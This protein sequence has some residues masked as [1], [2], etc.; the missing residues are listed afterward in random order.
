MIMA[1]KYVVV[2]I[3]TTGLDRFKD[4]INYIGFYHPE[5]DYYYIMTEWDEEKVI[6]LTKGRKTILQNGKFDVNFI[7]EKHGYIMHIDIDTLLMAYL[8]VS[9]IRESFSLKKL[10]MKYVGAPDWDVALEEKTGT[11]KAT[12]EYLKGDLKWTWELYKYFRGK[13]SDNHIRLMAK[14]L[15]PALNAYAGIEFRGIYLDKEKLDESFAMLTDEK[16]SALDTLKDYADINWNS[17]KQIREVL[18]EQMGLPVTKRTKTG[19]PSTAKSVLKKLALNHEIAEHLLE[20]K[21]YAKQL[22]FVSKW[23]EIQVNG[24]LYPSFNLTTTA[25][26]RTSSSGPNIQQV[27][28]NK[29][30]RSIFTA[31]TGYTFA[32]IDYSQIELRIG[33]VIANV[34]KF[35]E[36]YKNDGDIHTL[37]AQKLAGTKNITKED[38]TNAKAVNFGF[39]YGMMEE[40]FQEYAYD[41]FGL[42]LTL[43]EAKLFR[44]K[45]FANYPELEHWHKWQVHR[46]K[47]F[48][49]STNLFGRFR[50]LP[51]LVSRDWFKK[52]QDER[53]AINTPVQATASDIVLSGLVDVYN[54]LVMGEY[55]DKLFIVATVHDSL[56]FEIKDEIVDEVLPKIKERMEKPRLLEYFDVDLKGVPLKVDI[57]LGAWGKGKEIQI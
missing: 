2:D 28:R 35:I 53:R 49:G 8:T 27:P 7:R 42:K 48:R 55:R 24:R 51:N 5:N 26:G 20:Y 50:P 15:I 44:A 46:F 21:D 33:G 3:E 23:E 12:E 29:S 56:M 19:K 9:N 25:T 39:I 32:N 11:G 10:A 47:P 57:E 17:H 52:S 54:D 1:N 43:A 38:R 22:E 16:Q 6:E 14:L 37:T 30:I 41:T 13:M 4:T 18:F 40:S 36:T 45:F 31:P 34:P